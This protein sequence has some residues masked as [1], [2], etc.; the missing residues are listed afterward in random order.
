VKEE[1]D[2]PP[3]SSPDPSTIRPDIKKLTG[4]GKRAIRYY[5][6]CTKCGREVKAKSKRPAR[7][8]I[9]E[10]CRRKVM[11]DYSEINKKRNG[12]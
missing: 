4:H 12:D 6:I 8:V 11:L 5:A 7:Y 1:S 3:S 10:D 9:C 2:K